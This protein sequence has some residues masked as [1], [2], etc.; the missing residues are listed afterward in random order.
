MRILTWMK[1]T[2]LAHQGTGRKKGIQNCQ[3][4]EAPRNIFRSEPSIVNQ[5]LTRCISKLQFFFK[6][7]W[8][9]NTLRGYWS[10]RVQE[11]LLLLWDEQWKHLPLFLRW[12]ELYERHQE[13]QTWPMF[14][15]YSRIGAN[16]SISKTDNLANG[17]Q[18]WKCKVVQLIV[19]PI[20]LVNVE[21]VWFLEDGIG[22]GREFLDL[23]PQIINIRGDFSGVVI[24]YSLTFFDECFCESPHT[25]WISQGAEIKFFGEDW[26]MGKEML[27]VTGSCYTLSFCLSSRV[28]T[29]TTLHDGYDL[30]LSF[31]WVAKQRLEVPQP[32]TEVL[33]LFLSGSIKTK[34]HEI[35]HH[36]IKINIKK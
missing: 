27:P 29:N 10:C 23:L 34:T 11:Q 6:Y 12:G 26:K 21:E 7:Y 15:H 25:L 2:H 14:W 22:R 16:H 30:L 28:P 5:S 24:H 13:R 31:F 9:R 35:N 8:R 33:V 32:L 17:V 18:V 3:L 4:V 1:S 19:S 36:L 20:L